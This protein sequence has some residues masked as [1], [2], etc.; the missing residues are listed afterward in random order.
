MSRWQAIVFDLDDTLY[1]ER[2][3]V[4]SGFRA[5]AAWAEAHL[6]IPSGDGFAELRDLFER[7]VR[8]DTFD[9]WLSARAMEPRDLVPQ[10]VRAYREHEPLLAPF[11]EVPQLLHS[12]HQS[13]R[14]GLLS[15]GY[16]AVQQ[17]KLAALGLAHHFDAIVFS[18]EWGRQAWKPS[19]TPF[20]AILERLE[21]AASQTAYVGDNPLKD[22]LG[23]RRAGL[24]TVWVHRSGGEYAAQSPPAA[25]YA[26]DLT[27]D[28]LSTLRAVIQRE[29]NTTG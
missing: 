17:R 7:G 1:P 14:L 13:H 23:A 20:E 26:P 3:Y 21:C 11:P 24:F 10:L 12:L 5:V 15:D 22:F 18:D 6:G 4:L 9:R 2:E 29:W 28:G 27:I 8:G 19:T 16:L 25:E